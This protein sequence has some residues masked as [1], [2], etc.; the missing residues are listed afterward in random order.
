MAGLSAV[1]IVLLGASY[2][3]TLAGQHP[4]GTVLVQL[5]S[6]GGDRLAPTT[7]QVG[8]RSVTVSGPAP[9][10]PDVHQAASLQLPPGSYQLRVGGTSQP[11]PLTVSANQVEPVLLAV[12][13]GELVAGGVYAGTENF[14]LGIGELKGKLLP[15][16]SFSLVDQDG[17]P[18]TP[19]SLLGR[20]TVIAAFHTNCHQTCPLYTAL[21]FQLRKSAPEA[22]LLEVTTDA[23]T[24]TP[25]VLAG[26]RQQVG[27]TWD[28]ATGS[29]E[30]ITEFWAPFGVEPS[31]GDTHTSA[32]V[33]VDA[34]GYVRAAYV[35]APDVGGRVPAALTGQLDAA[36]RE[37]LASH[38][39][40]WGAPQVLES[41]RT[42]VSAGPEPTGH[43]APAFSLPALSGSKV[44]LE[45]SRGRPVI[46][47]FWWSGCVPCRTEMPML[48]RFADQH[49]DVSLL[50]I[51][52]SDSP[53]AARAF[54][55]SMGVKAPVL[56][57][58]DGS[59]MA[60]YHVA[61]FPTTI[62]VGP[63]G[64]QRF[65]HTGE[66]DEGALAQQISNLSGR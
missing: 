19:A 25:S 43:Q 27:A 66:V 61:Y 36:G 34:H 60:A 28:F 53:Q 3:L 49:P 42:L 30:A 15:V 44:S 33:L 10:A 31:S 64:V 54:A 11:S 45:E 47:N 22:R 41:L 51:D 62:V 35:G 50:L 24:D 26:Y 38:G 7:V 37:L 6:S 65:V 8:S 40:G 5:A 58:Q 56:M 17:R 52:S 13:H 39:D 20:D 4:S 14:N 2:F 63:D 57:D 23:A 48:Q 59:T 29:P 12:S 1:L 16:P 32:L 21:M 9:R 55:Q 46:L 18:L